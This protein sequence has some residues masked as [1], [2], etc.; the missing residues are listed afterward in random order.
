MKYRNEYITNCS[1]YIYGYFT[2]KKEAVKALKTGIL[3]NPIHEELKP[4]AG[5]TVRV[6]DGYTIASIEAK[7]RNF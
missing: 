3:K 6:K 5:Y 1:C 7:E 4:K 2:S